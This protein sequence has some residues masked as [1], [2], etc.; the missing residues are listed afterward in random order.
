MKKITIIDYGSGNLHSIAKAF[1]K[2]SESRNITVKVSDNYRDIEQATN[3]VLPGVGAYDDCI[4]GLKNKDGILQS[5]TEAVMVKKKPFLGVCVGMQLLSDFGEENSN[6]KSSN[7]AGLGWISGV[8]K[9]LPT[10]T[11][12]KIPHMGW[13]Q[14]DIKQNHDIFRNISN[15]S[16]FYFVHS[17]QFQC[18]NESDILASTNYGD[19]F[20]SVIAKENIIAA[21]FHPEKSQNSGLKFISNFIEL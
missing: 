19:E 20:T 11:N 16:D 8:V 18:R 14:V 21:Q 13:N 17:Y 5:L 4:L 9:S 1:E 10:N 12:L 2:Q 6:N 7:H 3:I 15:G